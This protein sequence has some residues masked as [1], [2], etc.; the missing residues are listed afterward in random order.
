[1]SASNEIPRNVGA[2][3][4]ALPVTQVVQ[5]GY[6]SGCG[7]CAYAHGLPMRLN[8][9]G[10]YLPIIDVETASDSAWI[11]R[12]QN[13]EVC[14]FLSPD[15]DEDVLARA[16]YADS[17]QHDPRIGFH[18]AI[19]AG[20]VNEGDFRTNGTSGGFGT[21]LGVELLRRGHIDAIVHVHAVTR[22]GSEDPFFRYA[23]SR[24]A[25]EARL[26]AKSRYH[27][28]EIASVMN[29]VRNSPGRYLFVGV[30]CMCKAVRRLQRL[31]AVLAERIPY[32]MS[33]VCGH[34]KTV[35][36]TLSLAWAAGIPPAEAAAFTYRKKGP[37]IPANHYVF[38]AKSVPPASAVVTEDASLVVGGKWNSCAMMLKACDYCDD[39][40]GETADISVGD[41][42]IEPYMKDT[43]GTNMLIV[44][45]PRIHAIIQEAASDARITVAALT[46]DQAA[47]AQ[48]GGLRHRREG[49]AFRLGEAQRDGRWTPVKRVAPANDAIPEERR[50]IYRARSEYAAASKR[51]FRNALDA[52]DYSV[53]TLEMKPFET[54]FRELELRSG[55]LYSLLRSIFGERLLRKL[56]R[57]VKTMGF[58]AARRRKF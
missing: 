17:C 36:W 23:I 10:E 44:R 46:A 40:V 15:L 37:T 54:R 4:T 28:V 35:H 20:Y 41:A 30:P 38:V 53:Y 47:H 3:A 42:W 18:S 24:T 2:P 56:T 21:W 31:D 29:E 57:A 7:A 1:M 16:R 5:G 50:R 39:V 25:E 52:D 12:S 13:A 9:Y 55:R 26:H 48:A 58:S 51:A 8:N 19:Y 27:V 43:A 32:V 34:L 49:L 14:P 6:C 22:H 45:D 33:L 11:P